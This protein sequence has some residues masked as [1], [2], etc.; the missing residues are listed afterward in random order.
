MVLNIARAATLRCSVTL[1]LILHV[2]V[3][4]LLQ[5]SKQLQLVG[6]LEQN[7]VKNCR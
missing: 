5:R 4:V 2:L 7:K 3:K 1:A 6:T